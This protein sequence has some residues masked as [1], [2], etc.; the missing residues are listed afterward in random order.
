MDEFN[1]KVQGRKR[2]RMILCVFAAL[3]STVCNQ[4]NGQQNRACNF[5]LTPEGHDVL[6][7]RG[8]NKGI[9]KGSPAKRSRCHCFVSS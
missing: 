8:Q 5:F 2:L 9:K 3:Q 6:R 1:A 4:H 7:W